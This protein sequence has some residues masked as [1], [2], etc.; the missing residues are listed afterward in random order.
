VRGSTLAAQPR[1]VPSKTS[2]SQRKFLGANVT[3]PSALTWN[4]P[5]QKARLIYAWRKAVG[6]RFA[7]SARVMHVAWTL[8]WLLKD[9]YAY[10]TDA[11]LSR[12]TGIPVNKIQEAL[13]ALED[14]GVIVRASVFVDGKP[15]RRIWPSKELLGELHPD[16]GASDTPRQEREINPRRGG[17]EYSRRGPTVAEL[18]KRGADQRE[19][20]R[21]QT[22]DDNRGSGRRSESHDAWVAPSDPERQGDVQRNAR[23]R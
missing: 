13:K 9:G 19:Q 5:G 1:S 2:A 16:A 15:R 11:Y 12:E 6:K 22:S 10:A 8:E 4:T 7:R 18:A 20:H 3:P 21:H 14:A 17:T 23:G